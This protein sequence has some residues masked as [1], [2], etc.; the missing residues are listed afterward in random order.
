MHSSLP[1]RPWKFTRHP[2]FNPPPSVNR[3]QKKPPTRWKKASAAGSVA[4]RPHYAKR[5][6]FRPYFELAVWSRGQEVLGVFYADACTWLS[7]D[8]TVPKSYKIF[9]YLNFAK[10]DGNPGYSRGSRGRAVRGG[11]GR[12][13]LR[14]LYKGSTFPL[15][16]HFFYIDWCYCILMYRFFF[17]LLQEY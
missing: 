15:K 6:A 4:K 16:L 11:W 13:E 17:F 1:R 9:N 10:M 7:S 5:I 14:I 3:K 8:F 2:P 12:S